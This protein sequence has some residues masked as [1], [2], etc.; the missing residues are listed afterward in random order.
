MRTSHT[1][2]KGQVHVPFVTMLNQ[3]DGGLPFSG[4]VFSFSVVLLSS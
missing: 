2:R 4:E 3:S 1:V